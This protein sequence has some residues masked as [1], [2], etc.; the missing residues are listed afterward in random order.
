MLYVFFTCHIFVPIFHGLSHYYILD[1]LVV[2]KSKGP[3]GYISTH[4][5]VCWFRIVINGLFTL[6]QT[7]SG[8]DSDSDS[9]PDGYFVLCR[10]RSHCTDSNSDPYLKS[11]PQ[12]QLYPILGGISISELGSESMSGNVNNHRKIH[13][14]SEHPIKFIVFL[15]LFIFAEEIW[16]AKIR[17]GKWWKLVFRCKDD[18]HC[19]FLTCTTRD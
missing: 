5:G 4:R 12:W 13:V 18:V 19:C 8:T 9:K 16:H 15:I 17:V 3:S 11:Y 7:D 14:K 10:T 6:P 2:Y 1:F